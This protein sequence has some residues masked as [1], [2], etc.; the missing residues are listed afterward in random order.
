[1]AGRTRQ[2]GY[3][4]IWGYFLARLQVGFGCHWH[5]TIKVALVPQF[6]GRHHPLELLQK[7]PASKGAT[8]RALCREGRRG[9]KPWGALMTS[10]AQPYFGRS[11]WPKTLRHS[12]AGEGRRH[13]MTGS[14]KFS[15][16]RTKSDTLYTRRMR[17]AVSLW[18]LQRQRVRGGAR[19][20]KRLRL[21]RHHRSPPL[22]YQPPTIALWIAPPFRNKKTK[23]TPRPSGPSGE[24]TEAQGHWGIEWAGGSRG[25]CW[26]KYTSTTA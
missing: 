3:C 25:R 14:S 6:G 9:S 11:Y 23:L 21:A 20:G 15:F 10:A 18:F 12:Q 17:G 13:L 1:M 22:A 2:F 24:P 7:R 19:S 16:S 26:R 8:R 5:N 4:K